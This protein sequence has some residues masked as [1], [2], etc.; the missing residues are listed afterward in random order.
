MRIDNKTC[1]RDLQPWAD[2]VWELESEDTNGHVHVGMNF[3]PS[4]VRADIH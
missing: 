4:R 3:A 2:S 1:G